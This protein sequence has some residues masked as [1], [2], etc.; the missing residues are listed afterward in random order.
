MSN[1]TVEPDQIDYSEGKR[2][3]ESLYNERTVVQHTWEDFLKLPKQSGYENN[4]KRVA[5]D[6]KLNVKDKQ[7][8]PYTTLADTAIP[9]EVDA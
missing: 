6:F 8:T 4:Q 9:L 7:N 1:I 3:M 2:I 5:N